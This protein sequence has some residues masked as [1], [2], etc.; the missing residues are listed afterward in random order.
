MSDVACTLNLNGVLQRISW[1]MT[2]EMPPHVPATLM[3]E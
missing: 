1:R 3:S 2:G